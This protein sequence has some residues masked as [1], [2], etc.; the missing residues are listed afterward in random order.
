MKRFSD[1]T[2]V[3]LFVIYG[4]EAVA[5]NLAHPITPN[6]IEYRN[7]PNYMFGV[8]FAA[9]SLTNF[10]LSPFWGNICNHIE[11]RKLLMISGI[12]YAVGQGMFG[13]ATNPLVMTMA[14]FVSGLFVSCMSIAAT[15]YVILHSPPE[16]KSRN[17]TI[18]ITTFTVMGTFGYFLGG[19]LGNINIFIPFLLQCILLSLSGILYYIFLKPNSVVKV[20]NYK[21]LIH[22]SN[23]V[24]SFIDIGPSLS[25]LVISLF[26]TVLFA[27]L[28]STS[29]T[30]NYAYYLQNTLG[31]SPLING[32]TK[33]LVGIFAT[34]FNFTITLMILRKNDVEKHL[35]YLFAVLASVLTIIGL[36]RSNPTIF[37]VLG[38][39]VM[40]L[41]TIQ[42]SILQDRNAAYAT[43]ENQGVMLG[44]HNA[45]KALGMIG[46]SLI[47]GFIYDFNPFYPFVMTLILYVLAMFSANKLRKRSCL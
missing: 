9:M 1:R 38:I 11:S 22:K 32:I 25:P 28:A 41:D 43:P 3:V 40:V 31:M 44:M 5:A 13:I 19:Y 27:S 45:M 17:L 35:S 20:A 14:R 8:V 24:Q 46:G 30:Q 34:I 6:L 26:A 4:F 42:V 2:V 39:V 18:T 33:G 29:F 15:Y 16:E 23:P 12:G 37:I 47:S 21:E 36:Y 10:L 7:M